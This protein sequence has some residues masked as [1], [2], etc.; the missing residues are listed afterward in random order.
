MANKKQRNRQKKVLGQTKKNVGRENT[1]HITAT[2]LPR[3][4]DLFKTVVMII[5]GSMAQAFITP[6][7]T[8]LLRMIIAN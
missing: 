8:E 2:I 4:G 6:A 3:N 1:T 5:L 7:I